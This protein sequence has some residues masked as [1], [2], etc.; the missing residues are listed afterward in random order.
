MGSFVRCADVASTS[1]A[2]HIQKG[3]ASLNMTQV[4]TGGRHNTDIAIPS[5][6]AGLVQR[7]LRNRNIFSSLLTF[8]L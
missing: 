8:S 4:V 3:V 1:S 6:L 2:I 7:S 5:P